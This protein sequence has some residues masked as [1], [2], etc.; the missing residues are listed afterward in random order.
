MTGLRRLLRVA[1]LGLAAI[2]APSFAAAQQSGVNVS[3]DFD[4]F[5]LSLSWSPSYCEAEGTGADRLQCATGRPYAFVVHGLWPQYDRGWPEF[6]P[7]SPARAPE[8]IVR[9][10]LD[11]MPSEGLVR[12]QWTKHGTCSGMTPEGY[13]EAT[14]RARARVSI[15]TIFS[16]VGLRSMVRPSD[17]ESAFLQT[18]PGLSGDAIAVTCD[19]QRL[20][21]VRICMDQFSLDFRACPGVTGRACRLDRAAMPP[22]QGG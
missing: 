2:S 12:H 17:V 8:G 3:G 22:V 15:P 16:S 6:C 5:V 14:R 4:Y 11:I 1:L 21:E 9:S 13:F 10:M 7:A 18:N 20:R 19:H